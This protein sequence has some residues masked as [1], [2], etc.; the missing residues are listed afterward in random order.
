LAQIMNDENYSVLVLPDSKIDKLLRALDTEI[1][2]QNQFG[3]NPY[4]NVT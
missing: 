3:C 2:P 1:Q 4:T